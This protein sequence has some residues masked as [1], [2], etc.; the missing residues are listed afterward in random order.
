[1][2]RNAPASGRG[3]FFEGGFQK[4]KKEK[5][6]MSYKYSKPGPPRAEAEFSC[7]GVGRNAKIPSYRFNRIGIV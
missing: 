2:F 4:E 6:I 3:T 1:M 5:I 7:F